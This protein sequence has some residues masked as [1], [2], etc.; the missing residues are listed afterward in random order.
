MIIVLGVVLLVGG[1][2]VFLGSANDHTMC[3]S[4]VVSGLASNQCQMIN[5]THYGGMVLLG[6][7]GLALLY[8]L[9]KRRRRYD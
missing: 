2:S 3:S 6:L 7:G 4:V 5:L 1:T 9:L 8:G